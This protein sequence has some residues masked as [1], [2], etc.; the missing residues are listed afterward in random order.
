[1]R[2]QVLSNYL[3]NQIAAGEVVERPASVLKEL[4]EN[5][6]DAGSTQ[7]DITIEQSGM[8]LLSVK[9]NGLGIVKED[10]ILALTPHATSKIFDYKDLMELNSYGFRGEALASIGSVSHLQISSRP[11]S[12]EIGWKIN[13]SGRAANQILSPIAMPNG[14]IIEMRS[15]FYNT[16]ARRQFL[17]SAKTE[18]CY[19]EE[20]FKKIALS[21]FEIGFS[22]THQQKLIRK[23]SKCH[24]NEDKL[25]R[26]SALLGKNFVDHAFNILSENNNL[27]LEGWMAHPTFT[28]ATADLQYFYVNGRIVR[29]KVVN[30]A[31]KL[32]L[33]ELC[34]PGRHPAY[35]LYLSLPPSEVD[36]N[37]HP[38]KSEVRFRESRVVH[39]F[40]AQSLQSA[41]EKLNEFNPEP[42]IKPKPNLNFEVI[43][44]STHLP[45]IL[46]LTQ[47][48]YIVS[49]LDEDLYLTDVVL[50]LQIFIF[51]V[52]MQEMNTGKITQRTLSSPLKLQ[53][54]HEIDFPK[55]AKY[56]ENIGFT[57][58][59]ISPT[60]LKL[61]IVPNCFDY[62]FSILKFEKIFNELLPMF[63]D[64]QNM[65]DI[66]L[67][68][69]DIVDIKE[70]FNLQEAQALLKLIY[71][72]DK[73]Y[74]SY[75]K[76]Y[77]KYF[78]LSHL[79]DK[80]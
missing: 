35:I 25:R 69:T 21:H 73:K 8:G 77:H 51:T 3:S 7:I 30:H 41:L 56:F 64:N 80:L 2:I 4:L 75:F 28:R 46:G 6:L 32:A 78:S 18:F 55:F 74:A 29:D 36:V 72:M 54:E 5:S 63:G 33:G 66:I 39:A 52:L 9:D 57:F 31:V 58:E 70:N 49:E 44:E 15:L 67:M 40:V 37:V 1:M 14:T 76:P 20:V 65:H 48:G 71:H 79:W 24:S 10:L 34:Q 12:E 47:N 16:P 60:H 23:L 27:K 26:V 22:F 19:L 13:S 68:L 45:K 62:N 61:L 42:K 50:S 59:Q 43:A 38:T 53:L 11:I 17:R